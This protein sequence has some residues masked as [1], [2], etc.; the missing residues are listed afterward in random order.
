VQY[1]P[2]R[3]TW[4]L[5]VLALIAG[6]TGCTSTAAKV[7]LAS[8]AVKLTACDLLNVATIQR[9]TGVSLPAGAAVKQQT[10]G[11]TVCNWESR[12]DQV[13]VQ[14][15]L[16]PGD[17]RAVFAERRGELAQLGTPR[18]VKIGGAESAYDIADQGVVCLL[19]AKGFVQVTTI[20]G[21]FD[22]KEHLA[23]A[24]AAVKGLAP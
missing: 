5:T 1:K 17:G 11:S 4:L 9:L 24:A 15:Q 14:V 3:V 23:L 12:K 21:A 10:S 7:S 2:V 8:R 20:G 13:A 6:A 16:T 22:T 19:T 18:A